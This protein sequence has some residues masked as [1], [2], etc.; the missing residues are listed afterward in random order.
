MENDNAEDVHEPPAQDHVPD[1]VRAD[2]LPVKDIP[3]DV[4]SDRLPVDN[5]ADRKSVV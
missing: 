1:D 4:R 3:R 2:E 5:I